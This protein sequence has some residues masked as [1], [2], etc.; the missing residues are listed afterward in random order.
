MGRLLDPARDQVGGVFGTVDYLAPEQVRDSHHVDVRADV[1]SLGC[2]LYHLLAGKT[3]FE[4]THPAARPSM[5]LNEEPRPIESRRR[6]STRCCV[7]ARA[8]ST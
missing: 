5:H 7:Q 4:E 3:P 6:R 1:Y 8:Y 2:T